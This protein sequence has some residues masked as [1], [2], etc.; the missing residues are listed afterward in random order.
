MRMRELMIAS[1]M[2]WYICTFPYLARD[3]TREGGF[4]MNGRFSLRLDGIQLGASGGGRE[5]DDVLMMAGCDV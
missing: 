5:G 2:P 4:A 1:E 3:G